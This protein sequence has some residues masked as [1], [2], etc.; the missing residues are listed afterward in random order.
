M[1]DPTP[2]SST[3]TTCSTAGRSRRAR[4]R[5]YARELRRDHRCPRCRRPRRSRRRRA[6]RPARGAVRARRRHRARAL[7]AEHRGRER[8]LLVS[9]DSTLLETAGRAVAH[10]STHTFFRDLAPREERGNRRGASPAGSTPR[11]SH[12]SNGF[13]EASGRP[14]APAR[15][16][17]EGEWWGPRKHGALCDGSTCK[18]GLCSL[19]HRASFTSSPT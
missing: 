19:V 1:P 8:V 9:S 10:L 18:F 2:T 16:R 11:P 6:A 4:A 14:Q 3:G 15:S 12:G 13:A 5:R 7:A 17:P